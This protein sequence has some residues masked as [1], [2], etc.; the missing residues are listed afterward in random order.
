MARGSLVSDAEHH[1]D[2]HV[3]ILKFLAP[4]AAIFVIWF[5]TLI[6]LWLKS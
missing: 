4:I 6:M 1:S 3:I 2:N 5:P